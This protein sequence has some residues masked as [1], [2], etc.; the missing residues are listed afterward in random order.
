NLKVRLPVLRITGSLLNVSAS[1]TNYIHSITVRNLVSFP[2]RASRY[3]GRHLSVVCV[4]SQVRGNRAHSIPCESDRDILV[5]ECKRQGTCVCFYGF[6]CVSN[7][8]VTVRPRFHPPA[9]TIERQGEWSTDG[10]RQSE[11]AS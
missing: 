6:G 7:I 8:H 11:F 1:L 3:F 4:D 10:D 9:T 2:L 5:P